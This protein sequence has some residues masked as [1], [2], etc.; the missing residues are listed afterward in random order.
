M[1]FTWPGNQ[2]TSHRP[3][4]IATILALLVDLYCFHWP[5]AILP[6][7][8]RLHVSPLM[9]C[10]FWASSCGIILQP[11]RNS[12]LPAICQKKLGFVQNGCQAVAKNQED[13]DLEVLL[14]SSFS[15]PTTYNIMTTS[16]SMIYCA[17]EMQLRTHLDARC[18]ICNLKIQPITVLFLRATPGKRTSTSI[19]VQPRHLSRL[20]LWNHHHGLLEFLTVSELIT[21]TA[22]KAL[23]PKPPRLVSVRLGHDALLLRFLAE[24]CIQKSREAPSPLIWLKDNTR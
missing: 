14:G 24:V 8:E 1:S 3:A 7:R 17:T 2:D 12:Q 13:R 16:Q 20:W 10:R 22:G 18:L 5:L 19:K 4:D 9:L 15:S 11:A 6:G 21:E 23:I